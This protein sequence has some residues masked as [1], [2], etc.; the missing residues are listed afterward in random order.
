MYHWVV[1]YIPKKKGNAPPLGGVR[2]ICVGLV[3]Y[4]VWSSVRLSD[5]QSHL[6]SLYDFHQVRDVYLPSVFALTL[7]NVSIA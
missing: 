6:T 4:R 2:P 3:L 1:K 7:K 5:L